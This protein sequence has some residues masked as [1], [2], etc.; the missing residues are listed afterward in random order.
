MIP[1]DPYTGHAYPIATPKPNPVSFLPL[2]VEIRA[3]RSAETPSHHPPDPAPTSPTMSGTASVYMSAS[4]SARVTP[5]KAGPVS[6]ALPSWLG[7]SKESVLCSDSDADSPEQSSLPPWLGPQRKP[8][9]SEEFSNPGSN[10]Q[11]TG[12]LPP[13]L[14]SG[15]E[16]EAEDSDT[17]ERRAGRW[18]GTEAEAE[19]SD[20]PERR[21]G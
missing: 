19:D 12:S 5:V 15:T 20:T 17:P 8:G 7:V 4:S 11:N 6:S 16:A 2:Q 9:M 10:S 14:V 18:S 3:A 13:W 1:Q 21:A